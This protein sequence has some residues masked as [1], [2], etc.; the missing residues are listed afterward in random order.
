MQVV[1][2]RGG[3]HGTLEGMTLHIAPSRGWINDP[4]GLAYHHGRWHVFYQH[5]PAAAVHANIHWGHT[6]SADLVTWT[7]HPVAFA[8]TPG[9]PDSQ[10]CWSGVYFD[11][12]AD[13]PD[14]LA[15]AGEHGSA[16][17]TGVHDGAENTTVCLRRALDADL[18]T[19]SEPE[20]V[21]YTP[22]G[23]WQMRDPY[24]FTVEGHRYA[25]VGAGLEGKVPA[26]LLF[27]CQDLLHWRY[28]GPWLT[29][30]DPGTEWLGPAE[31]WECPQLVLLDGE[32]VLLVSVWNDHTLGALGYVVLDLDTSG[33][34]P[35]PTARAGGYADLAAHA[36]AAQILPADQRDAQDRPL[37]LAWIKHPGHPDGGPDAVAGCLSLP[38]RLYLADDVLVVWP[39]GALDS[40]LADP[41]THVLGAG[42]ELELP[43]AGRVRFTGPSTLVGAG[44]E[45]PISPTSHDI[46]VDA[47]IA[48]V[49]G[50]GP[51]TTLRADEPGWTL[52]A[53]GHVAAEVARLR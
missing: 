35:S 9:G 26:V 18:L 43:W 20:V 31:I 14:A 29:G 44:L 27:D 5:N 32:W 15:A 41:Q 11:P 51:A 12:P 23:V 38:T 24:L 10:G 3:K 42:D 2:R 4:N 30:N 53:G 52:R 21:A 25:I 17:Y 50:P 22:E 49:F 1:R 6:S 48:E 46:W 47:D 7:E 40:A 8:P 13:D 16:I 33:E 37:M 34:H 28:L 19:W 39:D 36:Y 45:I